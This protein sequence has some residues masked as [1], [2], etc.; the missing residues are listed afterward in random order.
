MT[1]ANLLKQSLTVQRWGVTGTD[2]YGNDVYGVSSST[3]VSGY[4]QQTEAQEVTLDRQTYIS[5]WLV[6]L[7]AG[8]GLDAND[9]IVYGGVTY[10]VIGPPADEWNPR[11]GVTD[12]REA[13]LRVVSG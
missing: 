13:R 2:D 11:L 7:P 9:R 4:L 12:H 6:V 8:T 3:T 1:L 5:D 10:E